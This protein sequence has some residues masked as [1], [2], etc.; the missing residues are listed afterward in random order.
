M[1]SF[2]SVFV[3]LT[4]FAG[5]LAAPGELMKRQST[6]SS[7]GTHNGFYYS[8]WTDGG[9]PVTYTNGPGGQYSVVWQ[10]GG[11]FVG[12]KGWNPGSARTITYSG[13]YQP[14][15]NSYLAIYGWTRSP[16]IE[17]YIVENFGTYNPS[18]GAT[19]KG[20][21]VS[22]GS[23]YDIY[24]STRTNA[25][26][27][28]G[29][30]TFQQYWSVRQNKRVGGSVNTATHFNAWAQVGLNLGTHDYQI[31]AT[32]G[33]FSS[34]SA[35]ITVGSSGSSPPPNTPPTTPPS[36]PPSGGGG[37]GSGGSCAAKWGQCGG[38]GW[39]GATCCVS[40]STCSAQNQWYSQ[41]T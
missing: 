23:T 12:G 33:Y 29:T 31:V 39:T 28:D 40:G 11:N 25:P 18:S 20:S 5:A 6:P 34:G 17:Y 8:W 10:S 24:V 22:D 21:V 2:T 7:T 35:T 13:T 4:A 27:I 3:A 32:E 36:T 9:S 1:V 16:L 26:S 38:S 37:G 30:R 15:G 41:C 19:K 14:N